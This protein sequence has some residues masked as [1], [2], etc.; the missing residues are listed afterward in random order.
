MIEQ[1]R[2][3]DAKN[4]TAKHTKHMKSG[5]SRFNSQPSTFNS[6]PPI[7]RKETLL[8]KLTRIGESG[9]RVLF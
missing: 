3:K 9:I 7:N 5:V 8:H 2:R 6:Q 4:F 1:P